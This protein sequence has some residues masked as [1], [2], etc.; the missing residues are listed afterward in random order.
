MNCAK[1]QSELRCSGAL[2]AADTAHMEDCD[3]CLEAWLDA[4]VTQALDAK[5]EV[6]IPA[7]F[8]ARVAA[9]VA[10]QRKAP[11]APRVGAPRSWGLLTAILLVA[12]GLVAM[13]MADPGA[14]NTRMGAVFMLLV[15][16][17][18]AGIALW[19]GT[20]GPGEGAR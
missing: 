7:D 3:V 20:G 19:L 1:I 5:P 6:H 12:V 16:S 11:V 17:E 14:L 15:A 10:A 4:T 2:S 18:I 9:R 8:A 13:A